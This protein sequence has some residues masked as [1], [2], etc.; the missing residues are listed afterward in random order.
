MTL[1]AVLLVII[2]FLAFFIYFNSLNP[3]MLTVFY[4]AGESFE[5]SLAILV[6]S[7]VLGGFILGLVLHLYSVVSG[8][9]RNLR[10]NRKDK[11]QR[12]DETLYREG[13]S[14]YLSGDLKRAAVLLQKVLEHE[15]GRI[16]CYIALAGVREQE[17]DAKQ[18]VELLQKARSLAPSSLEVL[19]KLASV[20]DGMGQAEEYLKVLEEILGIDRENR[21]ALRCLRDL[22]MRN[23]RWKQA[24]ETQKRLIKAVKAGPK[25]EAEKQILFYLRYEVACEAAKAGDFK[26]A[27]SEFREIVGK[28]PEFTPARV[29][30]GDSLLKRGDLDAAARMWQEGY[31]RQ[32]KAV[33]LARLEEACLLAEDPS[34]LL[35]YYRNSLRE[36]EAD[37]ML[38][39]FFGKLCLRLE[40]VEEAFEQ[41]STVE[42][43][44]ADFPGLHLLL[45]EAYRRRNRMDES[46]KSYKK[47]LGA[48]AQLNLGYECDCCGA[49]S[50][51]WKSR[52]QACGAWGQFSLPGRK[53]LE[54]ARPIE[55]KPI[56]HGGTAT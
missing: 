27:E 12:E 29:S 18:A 35:N 32:K 42:S 30:L 47:A 13:V 25:A 11:K 5:V 43:S 21:K 19:F 2:L 51:Q 38:R 39:F 40:I 7:S 44:G 52:C 55:L 49:E 54:N 33:F 23:G 56:P 45:A 20:Y 53:S 48:D 3:E 24:M 17:G 28:A 14:R 36:N 41:L 26:N 22:Q 6:V 16:E 4:A 31:G 37:M 46:V 50:P 10:R 8:G 15:P 1:I 34:R 9:F